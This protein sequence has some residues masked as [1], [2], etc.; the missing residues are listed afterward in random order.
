MLHLKPMLVPKWPKLAWVASLTEGE[1]EIR[2]L[3]GP[4]VEVGED[5]LAEAVWAGEFAA[6]DF[7]ETDLVFGTGIRCRKGT[8]VFVSSGSTVDRLW[9]VAIGK[10]TYVANSLPALLATTDLSLRSDYQGYSRDICTSVRGPQSGKRK[11]PT[12]GAPCRS[13]YFANLL[14]DGEALRETEKPNTAPSFACFGDYRDYLCESAASLG[15][16]SRSSS[17]QHQPVLATTVSTGY[18][19]AAGAVV[20]RWASCRQALTLRQSHSCWRGSDSG[21]AL[22]DRLGLECREYD[23]IVPHH[24]FEQT[25]WAAAGRPGDLNLAVFEYP[26]PLCVLFTGFHGDKIWAKTRTEINDPMQRGDISGLGLCEYRLWQGLF[27]CPVPFWG[28]RQRAAIQDLSSSA[29][30]QEWS[31]GNRYDRPVPRRLVEEQG[32]PRHLFGMRK[33]VTVTEAPFL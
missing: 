24:P 7:D 10:A 17:R 16:N 12:S 3:H 5:W 1:E 28:V 33:R 8:V 9:D 22:A 6:G 18:D 31:L 15:G 19:S 13:T 23:R 11:L 29:E 21:K 14:Y 30:M 25:L 27:H 26:G 20:A 32:V 4:M 2:V